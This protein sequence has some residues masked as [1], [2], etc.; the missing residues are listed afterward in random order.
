M[1]AALAAV[2]AMILLVR[3]GTR[4]L[5]AM[6]R[7][8]QGPEKLTLEATLALDPKRRL[9]LVRCDGKR[10]L[11]LTG[12]SGDLLLGWLPEAMVPSSSDLS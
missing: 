9:S 10:I 6:P 3:F 8:N 4:F 11:L 7:R 2:I 1:T 12:G 5:G